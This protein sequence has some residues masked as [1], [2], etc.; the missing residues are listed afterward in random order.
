MYIFFVACSS[1]V[2]MTTDVDKGDIKAQTCLCPELYQGDAEWAVYTIEDDVNKRLRRMA[3]RLHEIG[4]QRPSEQ[5]F[6]AAAVIA[7]CNDGL[8]DARSTLQHTR[9]LKT[10]FTNIPHRG[11]VGP[12]NY[13]D[14][15]A[16]LA[17]SHPVL[18]DQLVQLVTCVEC[19]VPEYVA[20]L[21][22]TWRYPLSASGATTDPQP[23]FSQLTSLPPA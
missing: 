17:E 16:R 3:N 22:N 21:R 7:L 10:I 23:T 2:N 20:A 15:P 6:A 1:K 4:I 14:D 9:L 8:R 13:P 11:L 12:L 19:K 18:W 5:T